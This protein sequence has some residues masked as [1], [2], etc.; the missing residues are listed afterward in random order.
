MLSI[1]W[2]A[3]SDIVAAYFYRKIFYREI[4]NG[5]DQYNLLQDQSAGYPDAAR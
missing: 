5:G 4:R 3:F 2:R 1:P